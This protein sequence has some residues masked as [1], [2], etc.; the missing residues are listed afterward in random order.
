MES[1]PVEVLV[2]VAYG[3]LA[4]AIPALV[5][6][7]LSGAASYTD[8]DR[9]GTP[10]VL[11]VAVPLVVAN[12]YLM[13]V[14]AFDQS[15]AV[16]LTLV[17]AVGTLSAL[18]AAS[19]GKVIGEK[20]PQDISSAVRP[21][22]TLSAAAIEAVD[23]AGQVTI[24]PAGEVGDVDGH[25]P[26][27]PEVEAAIT[28]EVW[29]LPADL[30][31]AE[32]ERR[33]ENRLASEYGLAEVHVDIDSRGVATVAAAP[34]TK[35]LSYEMETGYRAVSVE[36]PIPT[37]LSAGDE[38][39]VSAD[40]H[41]REGNVLSVSRAD[42]ETGRVTVAVPSED[43]GGLLESE[44]GQIV[45]TS[46][47]DSAEYTAFSLLDDAGRPVRKAVVGEDD[48]NA[49][50][51]DVAVLAVRSTDHSD[52]WTF[53]PDREALTPG[54]VAFVSGSTG[55]SAL[56]QFSADVVTNGGGGQ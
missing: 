39:S 56:K 48:W 30:P 44:R 55:S 50:D 7:V 1:L 42:G 14:V 17:V 12:S 21:D 49:F 28:D 8:D 5:V 16:R 41:R 4:G 34:T 47:G 15:Y 22:R 10:A 45:A 20:I 6:G 51:D 9:F 3:L 53:D 19:Q 2:G 18:L 35:D 31:L 40:G 27:P 24:R 43:A 38:V 36:C 32:L 37:G 29:R 33:L 13:G 23:S 52:G 54:A 25:P 46:A 11:A 26:L